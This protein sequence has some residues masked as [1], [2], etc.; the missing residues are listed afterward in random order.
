MSRI[1]T[2]TITE[3]LPGDVIIKT[4]RRGQ[5]QFSS[6]NEKLSE[7]ASH[8]TVYQQ[9]NVSGKI[10][11]NIIHSQNGGVQNGVKKMAMEKYVDR[12]SV[13]CVLGKHYVLRCKQLGVAEK[14]AL[15]ASKWA[16]A[17]SR[18]ESERRKKASEFGKV[19]LPTPYNSSRYEGA[20]EKEWSIE[21]IKAMTLYRVFKVYAR[22]KTSIVEPE[23]QLSLEAK[24]LSR[25]GVNCSGFVAYSH[26][27]ALIDS[28]F[29]NGLPKN[30]RK[31]LEA[32]ERHKKE[33]GIKKTKKI[34]I[35]M[36]MEL[37]KKIEL[38][39]LKND[40]QQLCIPIRGENI[41]SF[42][43]SALADSEHWKFQGYLCYVENEPYVIDYDSYLK[44]TKNETVSRSINV[45]REE[46]SAVGLLLP[47]AEEKPR[48]ELSSQVALSVFNAN[49][50]KKKTKQVAEPDISKMSSIEVHGRY[51]G[52]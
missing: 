52:H 42:V 22:N 8:A 34:S 29:P 50:T 12:C 33:K 1:D 25:H 48:L 4:E 49:D 44:L 51:G 40:Y 41:C 18:E 30:I 43:K 15:A 14:M 35:E 24:P 19:N 38:C 10:E 47:K 3:L 21:Y 39:V 2:E 37:S 13:D 46:L 28:I 16:P 7:T 17:I 20:P 26:R 32:I 31:V 23:S 36:L 45:S 5:R 6:L 11:R 27:V 9:R